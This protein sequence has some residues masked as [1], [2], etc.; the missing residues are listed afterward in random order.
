MTRLPNLC[1]SSARTFLVLGPPSLPNGAI[2]ID[3]K[4][5]AE[6]RH[7]VP[8]EHGQVAWP[9]EIPLE[10]K[11]TNDTP[12]ADKS[13]PNSELIPRVSP[14]VGVVGWRVTFWCILA[15]VLRR[16]FSV[17]V[18]IRLVA[19]DKMQHKSTWSLHQPL[20]KV[21]PTGKVPW[22]KF[23]SNFDTKR[24]VLDIP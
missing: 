8:L 13:C 6:D 5:I 11:R 18:K 23:V 15:Y 9:S 24:V 1:C 20:A 7:N 22:Q 17:Q 14:Y 3:P 2:C 12:V 21:G 19:D 4:L 10:K 16:H